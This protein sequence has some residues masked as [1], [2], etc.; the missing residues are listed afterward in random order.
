ME[1]SDVWRERAL[2]AL[3]VMASL[4]LIEY[5]TMKLFLFPSP[6]PEIAYP[7]PP[8]LLV[9]GGIELIVGLLILFGLFT[10]MA[11]FIASGE[12]AVAYFMEHAP[13]SFWPAISRGDL[14]ILFC[15]IFLYV[16]CAGPGALSLDVYF[17]SRR[18]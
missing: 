13:I 15:F 5:G 12:M 8:L 2:T 1:F 7:L 6:L 14:A 3:R 11:A 17:A 4:L 9:A 16:V 10:R 18:K